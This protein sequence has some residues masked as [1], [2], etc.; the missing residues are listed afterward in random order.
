MLP[1]SGI[2]S[3]SWKTALTHFS[4]RYKSACEIVEPS[5]YKLNSRKKEYA[6]KH[7]IVCFDH[8]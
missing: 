1:R 8:L 6:E 4:Q 2:R 7:T 5:M 3:K